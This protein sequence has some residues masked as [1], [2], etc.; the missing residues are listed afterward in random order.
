MAH[1]K[2]SGEEIE[3][4][5]TKSFDKEIQKNCSKLKPI[6]DSVILLGRLGPPF[7]GHRDDSHHHPNAGEYSSGGVGNFIECLGYRVRG[8]DTEVENHLKTC[9]KNAGYISKTSQNELIYCGKFIKDA[10]IKD[11][12]ESKFFSIL[13]DEASDCSNQEQSSL[14][15]LAKTVR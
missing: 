5:L 3:A 6:N 12:K 14:D 11:I 15:L 2:G 10:P 4:M 13:A 1:L 8:G 9:D 7:R